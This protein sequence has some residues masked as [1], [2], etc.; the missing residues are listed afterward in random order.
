LTKPVLV[1]SAGSVGPSM[2]SELARHGVPVRVSAGRPTAV[3]TLRNPVAQG[4]R[5]L[6]GHPMPGLAPVRRAFADNTAGVAIGCPGRGG[7]GREPEAGR[8]G[9]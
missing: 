2:A 8:R 1:A 3:G 9:P 7:S 6:V 5:D 4:V